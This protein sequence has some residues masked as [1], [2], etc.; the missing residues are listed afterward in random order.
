MRPDFR[1]N[2]LRTQKNQNIKYYTNNVYERAT[3]EYIQLES[4]FR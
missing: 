3:K 1:I 2:I 4:Y